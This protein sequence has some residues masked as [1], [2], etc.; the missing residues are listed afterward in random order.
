M[1][2]TLE[3]TESNFHLRQ[4]LPLDDVWAVMIY[5]FGDKSNDATWQLILVLDRANC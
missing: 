4:K 2:E 5:R 3:S 1:D